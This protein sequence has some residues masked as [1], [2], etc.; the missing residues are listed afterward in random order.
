MEQSEFAHVGQQID[1]TAHKAARAVS[2]V[3]DALDDGVAAA[4]RTARD[5]ADAA[6]ELLYNTKRRVQR[7]PLEAVAVT[8]AAGIAVGA[9][10]GWMMKRGKCCD[11]VN[12][13]EE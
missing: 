9:A 3:A 4:R 5:G 12:H 2:A 8:L 7:H 1:D 13:L 11:G 10:I 6:T